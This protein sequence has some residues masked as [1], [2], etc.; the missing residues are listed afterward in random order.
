[1]STGKHHSPHGLH[2]H[3]LEDVWS[4]CRV[5]AEASGEEEE[6]ESEDQAVEVGGWRG[7]GGGEEG[8]R[9]HRLDSARPRSYSPV[10]HS[11]GI[12]RTMLT[13]QQERTPHTEAKWMLFILFYF[14]LPL[15]GSKSTKKKSSRAQ[16]PAHTHTLIAQGL[17]GYEHQS[18]HS[19]SS[20]SV[21]VFSR[22]TER[23]RNSPVSV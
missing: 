6:E 5:H 17:N 3:R 13:G 2:W 4:P 23:N 18:S 21:F 22:G 19:R 9:K 8:G 16:T 15:E 20:L 11:S 14:F 10:E 1:M 7:S 12:T